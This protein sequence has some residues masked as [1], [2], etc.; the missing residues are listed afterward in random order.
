MYNAGSSINA[1]YVIMLEQRDINEKYLYLSSL[2]IWT[3]SFECCIYHQL[4][5]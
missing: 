1:I 5:I 2:Y 3:Q 4:Q